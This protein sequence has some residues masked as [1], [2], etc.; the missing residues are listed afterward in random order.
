MKIS[1]KKKTFKRYFNAELVCNELVFYLKTAA[2]L[3]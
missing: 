2:T 3:I 1:K